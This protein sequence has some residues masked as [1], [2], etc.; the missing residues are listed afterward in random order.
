VEGAVVE[1]KTPDGV[2]NAYL[3]RPDGALRR[4]VLFI[5]DAFG[6]RPAIEGMVD[7]V[8]ADGYVVLAPNVFYRAGRSPIG[9]QPDRGDPDGSASA[10]R[11]VLPLI[12]QLTPARIASDGGA[13]LEYLEGVAA[14][15]ALAITGY[16][17]GGRLAWRIRAAHPDRVA[18][19]AAFHTAG[20]VTDAPDSPH[21]SAADLWPVVAHFGFADED[22]G[23]TP[24]QIGTLERALQSAGV[25]YHAEVYVGAHHGYA[26][27]DLPAYDE[28][29]SER[30]F[31]ELRA[32]LQRT[33]D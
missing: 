28:A 6:L 10:F 24:E 13:Y 30:Q 22:P 18:A 1:I 9:A 32:L 8:A 3:V 4:G 12:E 31:R 33:L 11:A 25:R 23:M 17:M 20:L 29:A 15:G 26:M 5:S 21:R 2:A 16:C 7:R 27:A 14:P 19:L